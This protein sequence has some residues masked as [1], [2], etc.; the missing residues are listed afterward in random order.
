MCHTDIKNRFKFYEK[1]LLIILMCWPLKE[2]LIFT[3][4]FKE[5]SILSS[6]TYLEDKS[7]IL[8]ELKDFASLP[9]IV[10]LK[11]VYL[12]LKSKNWLRYIFALLVVV[13][14]LLLSNWS[15]QIAAYFSYLFLV[16]GLMLIGI[17]HGALDHL[18]SKKKNSCLF[19]F[20]LKYVVIAGLYFVFWQFFPLLALIV[21]VVYSCFHFGES[22]LIENNI[23]VD[24]IVAHFKAFAM[25]LS[26]LLFIIFSHFE[27]SLDIVANLAPF[28]ES[29]YLKLNFTI[30]SR[31][32]AGLSFVYIFI[33]SIKSK[34]WSYIGL[35][36]LLVLGAKVPLMLAFGFYFILQHSFNAWQHLK[37]GLNMNSIQLYK[38]SS[39]YTYSALVIF[40]L[41]AFYANEIISMNGL[42]AN[43]FIFIACIS[44]P[45]FFLMHIFY[46]IKNQ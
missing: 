26:I 6:F 37:Q 18:L 15:L 11:T 29:T 25:G 4:L 40:I 9:K 8:Q 19:F 20:L 3:R 24:S 7:T 42:I 39:I 22:E 23:Q 41:T 33:Q 12:Y 45:H 10:F 44:F 27:E 38:K 21:F 17:P 2:K 35:L 34:N 46:K 30:T 13:T 36:F 28:P 14:Y 1:F 5:Q 31:I 32:V 16:I 43:F